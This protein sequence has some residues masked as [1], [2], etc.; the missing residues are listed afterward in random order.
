MGNGYMVA[1]SY[2][3]MIIASSTK[4]TSYIFNN[5]I[6]SEIT[7]ILSNC[8]QSNV[9][10]SSVCQ[11]TGLHDK[12]GKEIYEGDVIRSFDSNRNEILHHIE[13]RDDMSRFVATLKASN[14]LAMPISSAISQEWIDEFDKE[15]IGDIYN[16]KKC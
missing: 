3:V 6:P 12:N 4:M 14:E 1:P 9:K 11:F 10:T 16:N 5:H 8:V 15:V 7:H 13:W 2:F